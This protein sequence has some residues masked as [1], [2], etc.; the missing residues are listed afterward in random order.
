MIFNNSKRRNIQIALG[1]LW[2]L[3]GVLQLQRQ[4]FT[5]NFASKVIANSALGQ[6]RVVN[7]P[8][9]LSIHM[10]MLHPAIFNSVIV[11][12]QL[13][14]GFLIL[15]KKSV[16]FGLI[17]SAGWALFVWYIGE[18][19][20][21]LLSSH[22]LILTGAPGAAL[23][24]ALIALA[25]LPKDSRSEE[26]S[27][28]HLPA[29]WLAGVWAILWVVGGIYQLLPGQNTI[30]DLSYMVSSNAQGAPGWLASVDLHVSNFIYNLG[31]KSTQISNMH[32]SA[33]QMTAMQNSSNRG[34]W[35]I[36]VLALVQ[37]L[38]G[39]LAIRSGFSRKAAIFLG[40]AI[41]LLLWVIGQNLGGYYTGLATDPNSGPLYILLGL[42]IL[43]GEQ[44]SF[45]KL[46]RDSA[47]LIKSIENL[48]T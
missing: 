6:P 25:V 38:V 4:M 9:N 13:S 2:L 8:I 42:A 27:K 39:L 10:F 29:Y 35:F 34:Y 40:I 45:R 47:K 43:V 44:F 11:I 21:G 24:Y 16:K 3:D 7:G 26:K 12:I 37:I 17:T 48:L 1:L 41:S 46:K 20:G 36:A 23:I 15:S 14:L 32:M 30:T 5:S 33:I 31:D 28:D 22:T 18:G 19:L